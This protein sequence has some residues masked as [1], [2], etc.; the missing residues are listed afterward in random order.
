MSSYLYIENRKSCIEAE[1]TINPRW[2]FHTSSNLS[3][4][5]NGSRDLFCISMPLLPGPPAG[6]AI[7]PASFL[8]KAPWS[9]FFILALTSKISS[10]MNSLSTL[11]SKSSG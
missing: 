3:P 7:F 9:F 10:A 6:F 11:W 1:R 2:N 4:P 8:A 5:V